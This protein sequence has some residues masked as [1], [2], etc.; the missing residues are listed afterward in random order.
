MPRN[1][2]VA[3]QRDFS[4]GLQ[5]RANQF[6]L[7][8]N[9][10]PDLM[11]VD[12]DP[13]GGVSLRRGTRIYAASGT[14]HDVHSMAQFH[15]PTVHQVVVG[16]AD[17]I[18]FSEDGNEWDTLVDDNTTSAPISA[19]QF[20]DALYVQNGV[21][22][23]I[24][25]DGTNATRLAQTWSEDFDTPGTGDMPIA[26]LVAAHNGHVWVAH[27]LEDSTAHPNRIRWSHPNQPEAWRELDY[28][29]IDPGVD[30]DEIVAIEP[31]SDHLLVFKR[32]STHVVYGFS[33]DTF[34]VQSVSRDVGAASAQ[35]VAGSPSG[36]WFWSPDLGVFRYSGR[37]LEWRFES[38]WPAVVDRDIP[39]TRQDE[40]HLGW[41]WN[42]LWV[43]VP[44][45]STGHRTFVHDPT[46][47]KA[48]A[49]TQYDLPLGAMLEYGPDTDRSIPLAALLGTEA[50]LELEVANQPF[51]NW[52]ETEALAT[53]ETTANF[54]QQR[55][56]AGSGGAGFSYWFGYLADGSPVAQ[57][58]VMWDGATLSVDADG[59]TTTIG[60]FSD[61]AALDDWLDANTVTMG[62][63]VWHTSNVVSQFAHV[64]RVNEVE[65]ASFEA[66]AGGGYFVGT[67]EGYSGVAVS[68]SPVVSSSGPSSHR[69]IDAWYTTPWFDMNQPAV[70]KQF[71]APYF[72]FLGDTEDRVRIDVYRDYDSS[73]RFK[74][75]HESVTDLA[76]GAVWGDFDWGEGAPDGLWAAEGRLHVVQRGSPLGTHR[77]V[78]LKITGPADNANWGM[79]ALSLVYTPKRI[80]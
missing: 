59:V 31:H 35:A 14:L 71:K 49:W 37:S 11:N 15:S 6:Q 5:L 30:G 80:R 60:T 51:D 62:V 69:H 74:T 63:E 48:G 68:G 45:G 54:F 21:D 40:V 23:P 72:V 8:A 46:L 32:R 4:G 52:G 36:V 34:Q 29:D 19:T 25:W 10:S 73:A 38:L 41:L 76:D 7:A 67:F 18:Q 2:Q 57:V 44:W 47:G 3:T 9:E 26:K 55:R 58:Y 28:I 56:L 17:E 78:Q 64:V 43:S 24:K 50:V 70:R 20:G 33:W 79:D 27:T 61:S 1:R 66:D 39:T 12:I 22:D 75:F 13:R 65:V 77:A 42:R 53:P 16:V